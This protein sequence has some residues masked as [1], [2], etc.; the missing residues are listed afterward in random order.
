MTVNIKLQEKIKT[1]VIQAEKSLLLALRQGE[2]LT[3]VAMHLNSPD[4]RNIW[5]GE[6]KTY[7]MLESRIKMGIGK[8]LVSIDYQVQG[9]DFDLINEDTVL[10]TLT[11]TETTTMKDGTSVTSNLTAI[12]ILWQRI[13]NVWRLGYLHA[14]EL[15]KEK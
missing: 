11:A 12:S 15:S 10:E 14:S 2:L 6:I 13:N 9:R 4:Y 3:G 7:Q 1:E 5:N 8:G